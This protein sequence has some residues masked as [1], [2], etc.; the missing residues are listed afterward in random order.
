MPITRARI[1]G[2]P[3]R[4]TGDLRKVHRKSAWPG[5]SCRPE[6]VCK[7]PV[8]AVTND[9]QRRPLGVG[10]LKQQKCMFSPSGGPK[11][12][13]TVLTAA[14]PPR[15]T[16]RLRGG[17]P[18]CLSRCCRLKV[19][20]SQI[21][22]PYKNASVDFRPG[23]SPPLQMRSLTLLHRRLPPNTGSGAGLGHV[24]MGGHKSRLHRQEPA[25]IRQILTGLYCAPGSV[26]GPGDPGSSRQWPRPLGAASPSR[27]C[28]GLQRPP[29]AI[30]GALTWPA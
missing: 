10:R 9:H 5:F 21:F 25:F 30:Q 27:G 22:L 3:K 12:E 24:F 16:G 18:S 1:Y 29:S 17:G 2:R 23:L 15:T 8:A 4:K 19:S 6:R 11:S 13:V 14:V 7:G 26:L 20:V 28:G